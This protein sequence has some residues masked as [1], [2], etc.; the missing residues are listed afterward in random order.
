MRD[1]QLAP[2]CCGPAGCSQCRLLKS[3]H[4]NYTYRYVSPYPEQQ[5]HSEFSEMACPLSE[6]YGICR[7]PTRN[8]IHEY[9]HT[10]TRKRNETSIN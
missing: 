10:R 5:S 1:Y 8:V 4:N 2:V 7:L 3:C 9:G 6:N